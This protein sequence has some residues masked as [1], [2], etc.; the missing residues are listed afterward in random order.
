MRG[1]STRQCSRLELT[2][3]ALPI[4]IT[5][6]VDGAGCSH[7]ATLAASPFKQTAPGSVV[8][9]LWAV[10]IA[11]GALLCCG[12]VEVVAATAAR[13]SIGSTG[14][15]LRADPYSRSA[16]IDICSGNCNSQKLFGKTKFCSRRL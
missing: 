1:G 13:A 8:F 7:A 6:S 11:G 3:D 15:I 14:S 16:S 5:Q 10:A 9:R 2:G 4:C 12:S